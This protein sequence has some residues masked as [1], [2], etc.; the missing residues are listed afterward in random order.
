MTDTI[1]LEAF[2]ENI[3]KQK[4][5]CVGDIQS[6]DK[7]IFG[8]YSSYNEEVIYRTKS[9]LVL[10]D[11]YVKHN[12]KFLKNTQFDVI[13]RIKETRD[14]QLAYTYIQH[15]TKPLFVAWYTNDLPQSIFNA[16]NNTKD[17]ITLVA[18]G[19]Q[20]PKQQ[21]SSVIW[22][23]KSTYEDVYS[24]LSL[25]TMNLDIKTILNETKANDVS[26]VW[27]CNGTSDKKGILC[28]FDFST[29]KSMVPSIN[30]SQ[31]S[32]YL[33]TLADALELK[34]T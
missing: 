14:L 19:V 31:A 23:T 34:E 13:F 25:R 24:F 29:T 17:D 3:R 33:R 16:L 28:W 20:S 5:Y 4:L 1:H 11:N 32:Y 10:S 30:Y 8:L 27:C 18:G 21:Y 26:L 9:I 6:L 12:P 22:S 7:M 15:C 2:S